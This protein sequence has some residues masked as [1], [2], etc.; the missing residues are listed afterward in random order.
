[1]TR[2][3]INENSS[4]AQ[5][6]EEFSEKYNGYVE[7]YEKAKK[8]RDALSAKKERKISVRRNIERFI[9]DL[10]ARDELLTGFDNCLW[11]TA[12]ERVTVKNDGALVFRFYSG[13]EVEN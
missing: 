7:K 5:D 12:V 6:Q 3:C 9:A 11:L 4:E 10:S 8:C 13:T 2:K 1:M